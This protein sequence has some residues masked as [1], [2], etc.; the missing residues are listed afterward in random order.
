M[1]FY[2]FQAVR[3]CIG[4]DCAAAAYIRTKRA[5][6]YGCRRSAAHSAHGVHPRLPSSWSIVCWPQQLH[7]AACSAGSRMTRAVTRQTWHRMLLN[8]LPTFHG[9][10]AVLGLADY[11][12]CVVHRASGANPVGRAWPTKIVNTSIIY[13][14]PYRS[15]S[16]GGCS[17]NARLERRMSASASLA[18]AYDLKRSN[19]RDAM[20]KYPPYSAA[21]WSVLYKSGADTLS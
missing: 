16:P 17:Q 20:L 4:H 10:P 11:V 5:S 8:G 14:G 1:S 2:P 13:L 7:V 12:A 19:A 9:A 21:S 3:N 6:R 15:L 18:P